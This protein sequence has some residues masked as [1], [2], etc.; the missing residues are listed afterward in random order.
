[1]TKIQPFYGTDVITLRALAAAHEDNAFI[2]HEYNNRYM[3]DEDPLEFLVPRETARYFLHVAADGL[4][5]AGATVYPKQ[6]GCCDRYP[7]GDVMAFSSVSVRPEYRNERHASTLLSA[8]FRYAAAEQRVLTVTKFQ[9]LGQIYLA[10]AFPKIHTTH[11]DVP[12]LYA[13]LTEPM[14]AEKPYKIKCDA[15]GYSEIHYL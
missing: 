4:I 10:R 12:V 3:Y 9:P 8:V 5:V 6:K 7:Q 14:K 13:G 2:T 1:M 11:A 15:A